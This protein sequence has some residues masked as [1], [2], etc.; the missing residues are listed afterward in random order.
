MLHFSNVLTDSVF[1]FP[2]ADV[3]CE[4]DEPVSDPSSPPNSDIELEEE[5]WVTE[6][7]ETYGDLTE[8]GLDYISVLES[9]QSKINQ[10]RGHT[11]FDLACSQKVGNG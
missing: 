2:G 6:L 3:L 10:G 1:P 5:E 4:N 7:G 11:P 9:E 8:Q